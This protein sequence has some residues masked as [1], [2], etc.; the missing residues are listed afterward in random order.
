MHSAIQTLG[1]SLPCNFGAGA[2]IKF[3][4]ASVSDANGFNIGFGTIN[5]I[6]VSLTDAASNAL[7]LCVC[8]RRRSKD[9]GTRK[10]SQICMGFLDELRRGLVAWTA[11]KVDQYVQ[12][13]VLE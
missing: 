8:R 10:V 3:L 2:E 12:H 9:T 11:G 1:F 4:E 5:S 6:N 13:S 7:Q